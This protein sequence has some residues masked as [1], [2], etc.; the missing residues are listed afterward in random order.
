[1]IPQ[2]SITSDHED[3]AFDYQES[4]KPDIH[5]N[6]SLL[7]SEIDLANYQMKDAEV[8]SCTSRLNTYREHN[9]ADIDIV[10]TSSSKFQ[11]LQEFATSKTSVIARMQEL[12]SKPKSK[13]ESG[14]QMLHEKIRLKDKMIEDLKQTIK[15]LQ[16]QQIS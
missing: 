15:S 1:M 11:R 10:S 6:Q 5:T 13:L 14:G 4:F 2:N 8:I 9:T 7:I 12:S 16:L 3:S